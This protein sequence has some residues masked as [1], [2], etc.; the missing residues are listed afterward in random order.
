M[1]IHQK[2]LN[3]LQFESQAKE[4]TAKLRAE[5]DRLKQDHQI[6]LTELF[7]QH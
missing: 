2:N 4:E 5:L 3:L 1:I 7:E 6:Q